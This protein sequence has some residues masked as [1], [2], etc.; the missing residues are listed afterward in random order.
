MAPETSF[1]ELMARVRD[2]DPEAQRRL[3]EAYVRRLVGLARAHLDTVV[4]RVD[5]EDVVQSVFKSFFVRHAAGD[6]EL[7]GWQDLWSL[8][9]VITLRKC[10]RQNRD[11]RSGRRDVR[12]EQTPCPGGSGPWPQAASPEPS[13]EE[14]AVLAE[15]VEHLL[16]GL[17]GVDRQIVALTLQG[18]A[19]PRISEQAGCSERKVYRFQA[20]LRDY[21]ERLREEAA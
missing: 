3:F 8:L 18:E 15:L 2:R 5:A 11:A 13:P 1:G 19:V 9:A 14:A 21:L 17:E 12:R 10:S 4:R 16:C 6:W 20:Y 7:G